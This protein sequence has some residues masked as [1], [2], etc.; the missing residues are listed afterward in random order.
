M[1]IKTEVKVGIVGILAITIFI[2]GYH[3]MKGRNLV[4]HTSIYYALYENVKGLKV[5]DPVM[6]NGFRVGI[7]DYINKK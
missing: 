1:K 5:S 2:W 7:I 3:F 4:K 6:I